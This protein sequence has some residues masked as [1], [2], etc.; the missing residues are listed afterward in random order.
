M[1]SWLPP[2]YISKHDTMLTAVSMISMQSHHHQMFSELVFLAIRCSPSDQYLLNLLFT[3][4]SFLPYTELVLQLNG[5]R[6]HNNSIVDPSDIGEGENGL[7]CL[8]NKV[9]CCRDDGGLL[10]SRGEWYNPE[11]VDLPHKDGLGGAEGFYNNRGNSTVRLNRVGTGPSDFS[12]GLFRCEIPDTND[13]F[14]NLYVG[15]YPTGSG[16]V[17]ER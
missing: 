5:E 17:I 13:V 8:T 14:Q 16:T 3:N 1:L 7:F 12:G 6:F 11:G 4:V 10:R 2:E 9:N 15:L